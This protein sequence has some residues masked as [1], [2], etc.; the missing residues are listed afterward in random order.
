MKY[1]AALLLFL[2]A[3]GG[4][5]GAVDLSVDLR[6]DYVPGVEF[7]GVRVLV[8]GAVAAEALSGSESYVSG[9][10]VAEVAGLDPEPRRAVALELVAG[11]A[12]IARR[13]VVVSH[14]DDLAV[15]LVLSR[16]CGGVVCSEQDGVADRCLGGRCVDPGCVEGDE[17]VCEPPQCAVAADCLAAASCAEASC[18]AGVCLFGGD[19]CGETAWCDPDVGCRS[20]LPCEPPLGETLTLALGRSASPGL[21]ARPRELRMGPTGDELWLAIRGS[22]SELG[23]TYSDLALVRV[24]CEG[25]VEPPRLVLEDVHAPELSMGNPVVLSVGAGE[26]TP[27]RVVTLDPGTGETQSTVELVSDAIPRGALWTPEGPRVLEV[28]NDGELNRLGWTPY[29]LDG[30]P[31]GSFELV[32]PDDP[33]FHSRPTLVSAPRA[34]V[35]YS[36]RDPEERNNAVNSVGVVVG[37]GGPVHLY[38]RYVTRYRYAEAVWRGDDLWI[39]PPPLGIEGVG[40]EGVV[41][42]LHRVEPDGTVTEYELPAPPAGAGDFVVA[43]STLGADGLAV[44]WIR[45]FLDGAEDTFFVRRVDPVATGIDPGPEV[46]VPTVNYPTNWVDTSDDARQRI[47]PLPGEGILFV[48]WVE[49]GEDTLSGSVFGRYLSL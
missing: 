39:A 14:L 24:G 46:E 27:P 21:S 36:R 38:E 37:G 23:T 18:E 26:A 35:V 22:Y 17:E 12:V 43:L 49:R 2:V 8:D 3:C 47:G 41:V 28:R 32:A 9:L 16:D 7:T 30:E 48:A 29:G 25:L 5:G 4:D 20:L 13:E 19:A 11:A 31:T 44:G 15:T 10:R 45:R 34:A 42:R 33:W 1:A 6:T 40:V